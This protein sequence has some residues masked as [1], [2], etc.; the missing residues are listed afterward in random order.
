M[1]NKVMGLEIDKFK[2]WTGLND[3][4]QGLGKNIKKYS[5]PNSNY[6]SSMSGGF[7]FNNDRRAVGDTSVTQF[8]Q[9]IKK[10]DY[11]PMN[12]KDIDGASSKIKSHIMKSIYE[13]KSSIDN[14][15]KSTSNLDNGMRYE[16]SDRGSD[17]A[18]DTKRFM[19][20]D[21]IPGAQSKDNHSITDKEKY[22]ILSNSPSIGQVF[23][24]SQYYT[25]QRDRQ[26]KLPFTRRL[27]KGKNLAD[28]SLTCTINPFTG[29]PIN[30]PYLNISLEGPNERMKRNIERLAEDDIVNIRA[31]RIIS[32]ESHK[33]GLNKDHEAHSR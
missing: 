25:K 1:L 28:R 12:V 3:E 30:N 29:E 5:S 15:L 33:L 26:G 11:N 14:Y 24:S 9:I 21:D 4:S 22:M 2:A 23:E 8:S 13:K 18:Y 32:K 19:R 10:N 17:R 27:N 31:K 16:Q 6:K 7:A 20:V